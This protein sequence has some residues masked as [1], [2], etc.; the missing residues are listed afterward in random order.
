MLI[1]TYF[2]YT[3]IIEILYSTYY[4]PNGGMEVLMILHFCLQ[5]LF[6]FFY[7]YVK[8]CINYKLD[9]R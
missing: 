4:K 2:Y 8:N 3:K 5:N 1:V 7:V 6:F 9:F